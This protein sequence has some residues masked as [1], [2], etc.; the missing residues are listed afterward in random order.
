M[1]F[2]SIIYENVDYK[3]IPCFNYVKRMKNTERLIAIILLVAA[4]VF[5]AIFV[6]VAT[7]RA[8]TSLE[9]V[10]LQLL[11]FL[12]GLSGSFILGRQS[13]RK[14]ARDIIKPHAR[15]AFRRVLS[16]YNGLSR[17]ATIIS[18]R[19]SSNKDAMSDEVIMAKCESIL[20]EYINTADDALEDWRD[21]IP[22]DVDEL[23][24]RLKKQTDEEVQ[25]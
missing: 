10:S 4:L 24:K 2:T 19:H 12:F 6:I 14:V 16:L 17:L 25:Q 18:Q 3:A 20:T 1:I 9:S 5:V 8:L 21:I 11:I 15:S 23:H 7:N 22:E 13:A